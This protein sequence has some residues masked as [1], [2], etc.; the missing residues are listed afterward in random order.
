MTG[1]RLGGLFVIIIGFYLVLFADPLG[2]FNA[3]FDK[4][5]PRPHQKFTFFGG[6]LAIL[7]GILILIIG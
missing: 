7:V 4:S 6:L 5:D 3:K 2:R 1:D